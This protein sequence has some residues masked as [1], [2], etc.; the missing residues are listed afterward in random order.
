MGNQL[1]E[2]ILRQGTLLLLGISVAWIAA[3]SAQQAEDP[4]ATVI[5]VNGK[6][7]WREHSEAAWKV[8]TMGLQLYSGNELRTAELSR[9][10]IVFTSDAS[11]VLINESTEMVIE[12]KGKRFERPK[13]RVNLFVGEMYC[14][15]KEGGKFEAETPSCVASVRGTEFD[16]ACDITGFTTLIVVEGL[17]DFINEFGQI[18]AQANTQSTSEPGQPPSEPE[19]ISGDEIRQ[20][21]EWTGQ[22]EPKWQLNLAPEGN[23]GRQELGVASTLRIRANLRK[24]G[25]LDPTCNVTLNPLTAGLPQVVFS[26]DGGNTWTTSPV[27]TLSRGEKS[28]SVRGDQAGSARIVA[29]ASDCAPGETTITFAAPKEHRT[30]EMEFRNPEGQTKKVTIELESK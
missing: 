13:N 28:F 22:V 9:A 1:M 5:R 23:G 20:Q 19:P 16:V 15:V 14:K 25:Q 7:E 4:I 24:T 27:I 26:T 12:A 10:T 6:L 18:L 21:T 2:R 17:V 11:R 29:T 3:S 30:I 8:A